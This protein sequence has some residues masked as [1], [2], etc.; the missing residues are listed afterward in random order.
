MW[1]RL[2]IMKNDYIDAGFSRKIILSDEAHFHFS[3]AL[4]IAKIVW[5][6]KKPEVWLAKNKCT[7]NMSLFGADFGQ[8]TSYFFENEAV[9]GAR[10]RD[11]ISS[12]CQN[13]MMWF[14]QD[15]A[16]CHMKQFNYCTRHFLDQNWPSRS[17]DLTPLDFF[18]WGYLRSVS[19][20]PQPHYKRKL[21]EIQPQLCRKITKNLDER[22]LYTLWFA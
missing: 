11:T 2:L 1:N 16:T 15:D 6:S 20:I 22:C 10:Y 5:R 12:F 4:L 7:H 3:M 19:T 17:C 13:W 21:N 9:N 18:L 14:Q 8:E